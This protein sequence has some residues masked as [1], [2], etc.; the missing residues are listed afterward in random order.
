MISVLTMAVLLPV[1][2]EQENLACL[3]FDSQ[4]EAQQRLEEDPSDPDGLDGPPGEAFTGIEGVACED[5]PPP[6]DLTPV[7]PPDD[8][9]IRCLLL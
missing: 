1:A 9:P 7:L 8:G 2:S 3:E 4:A 6:E 5:L